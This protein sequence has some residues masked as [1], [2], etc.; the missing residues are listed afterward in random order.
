MLEMCIVIAHHHESL[1]PTLGHRDR[2]TGGEGDTMEGADPRKWEWGGVT[3]VCRQPN[4]GR[5]KLQVEVGVSD[6][7]VAGWP[8]REGACRV[9]LP[10]PRREGRGDPWRGDGQAADGGG[11]PLGTQGDPGGGQL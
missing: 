4:V 11:R 9:G 3:C 1:L 2:A 8:R 10:L 6:V 5:T 7:P